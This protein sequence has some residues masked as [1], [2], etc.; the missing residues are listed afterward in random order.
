MKKYLLSIFFCSIS[1]N[2]FAESKILYL[3]INFLLQQSE[4]GK[5]I[6]N[7]LIKISKKN[8]ADYKK[9]EN[10]IKTEEENILKQKNLLKEEEFNLKVSE[11]KNKYNSYIKLKKSNNDKLINLRDKANKKILININD[12]VTEYSINNE[13]SLVLEKKNIVLGKTDL[14]ITDEIFILLNKKIKKVELE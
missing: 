2:A 3:D 12:I 8:N 6:N 10:S 7:E 11:F 1:I 9:I 13:V 4:A 5:Y 14:D